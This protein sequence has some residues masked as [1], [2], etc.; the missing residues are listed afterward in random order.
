MVSPSIVRHTLATATRF[1]SN[2][3][4]QVGAKEIPKHF[5]VAMLVV[6]GF[7]L[8][9]L[10]A[11]AIYLHLVHG[12]WQMKTVG[13]I[14]FT[15]RVRHRHAILLYLVIM[16]P[17][18]QLCAIQVSLAKHSRTHAAVPVIGSAA[19]QESTNSALACIVQQL[20]TM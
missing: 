18:T 12:M 8:R 15:V 13:M 2:I 20:G 4:I 17:A 5:M 6:V 14:M 16:H 19:A 3:A 10:I 9:N 1:A 11:S 7:Y